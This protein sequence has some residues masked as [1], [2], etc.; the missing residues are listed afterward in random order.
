M[1]GAIAAGHPLTAEAGARVLAEGGSAVDA[2][3]AASFASW[4]TESMLSG[5]GAGGFFLV[6]D[7]TS[8]RT[9]LADFFVCEPGVG[10]GKREYAEMKQVDVAF[11]PDSL[12]AF[13]IGEVS[14]AVPGASK[15]LE[16]VHRR[17]GKL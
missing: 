12:Q 7:A 1:R 9:R 16:E 11:Q 17:F 6:H 14:C 2:C 10:A 8:A 3:I 4:V 15:G 5:P 13:S